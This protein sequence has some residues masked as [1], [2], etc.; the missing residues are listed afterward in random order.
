M[1]PG[2][3][4]ALVHEPASG[5]SPNKR[6]RHPEKANLTFP[7]NAEIEIQQAFVPAA[8]VQYVDL[9]ARI[10]QKMSELD[11]GHQ[12]SAGPKMLVTY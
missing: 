1:R 12:Q 4:E 7:I 8:C 2:D 10:A 3:L 9:N 11:F 5:T 6:R